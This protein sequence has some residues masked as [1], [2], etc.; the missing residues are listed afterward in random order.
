MSPGNEKPQTKPGGKALVVSLHDV[1]PLTW[2]PCRR[3][4]AELDH[5]GVPVT[6]LLVIPNHHRRG[7]FLD[8]PPFCTWL[9]QQVARGNEAVLHG[10]SH[11][12]ESRPNESLRSRWIT[13][14]YTAGEGEFFDLT[15][16]DARAL[17][18]RGLDDFQKAGLHPAGFIAPAWLLSAEAERAIR[19][20]SFGYTTRI[21]GVL[22][23]QRRGFHP[24]R[25]LCWSVRAAWRRALSL[26]WNAAL[27]RRLA[28][29]PLMR[30]AVH[31]VD[32]AHP[33]IWKQITTRISE[34]ARDRTVQ[35]YEW[36]LA[37]RNAATTPD[38]AA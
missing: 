29:A 38:H 31:P 14:T 20:L 32:I 9:A 5:I 2:E 27:F 8:D 3:I 28:N 25:S 17:A 10:Y 15:Y 36:W 18:S 11:L 23:L 4:L 6:S 7:H 35:S 33:R 13:G 22:D 12:R 1:S 34:A 37:D 19:D 21:G 24:A 26:A 16:E 30:I